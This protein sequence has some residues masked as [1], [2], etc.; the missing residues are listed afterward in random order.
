MLTV[1]AAFALVVLGGVV[2]VTESG[3]GCPD[4]PLCQGRIFPPLET[5]A[6]IEYSHRLVA[7][8]ILGPLIVAT[9]AAAWVS[10]RRDR[11]LVVPATAGLVLMLAQALLGGATVLTGL[12]GWI[13]AAHLA[14]GEVLMACLIL[15]AVVAHFGPPV[16]PRRLHNTAGALHFP[17]LALVSGL[18]IYLIIISGSVVT[19]TG[20]TGACSN[21]P[22]CQFQL[23]PGGGLPLIHMSHRVVTVIFGL[24]FLYTLYAAYQKHFKTAQLRWLSA[25]AAVLFAAQV[26][27]GAATVFMHFPAELRALHL[28]LAT[29]IWGTVA[30]LAVLSLIKSGEDLPEASDA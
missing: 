18:G 10:Y 23:L 28:S 24:I 26:G 6:I 5:S 16:L 9:C 17:V 4:W 13:V 25:I 15:V 30:A 3:L 7:S 21:W 14:L 22:L 19:N 11:W 27:V 29:L 1:L 20:A 8:A 12:P 2:R